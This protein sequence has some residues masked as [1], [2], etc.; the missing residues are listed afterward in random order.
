MSTVSQLIDNAEGLARDGDL[1]EAEELYRRVLTL[2]NDNTA[3]TYALGRLCSRDGRAAEAV[4]HYRR[5]LKQSGPSADCL[6]NLAAALAT[7]GKIAEAE[8][9]FAESIALDA[10]KPEAHFGHAICLESLDRKADAERA[11]RAAIAKK[12]AFVEA[13]NNLGALLLAQDR[14]SEA[15]PLLDQALSLN[16]DFLSARFNR[17][18]ACFALGRHVEAA[19]EFRIVLKSTPGQPDALNELGRCM[20]KQSKPHDA[21]AIF[22]EGARQHPTDPRF[23]VNLARS[24]ELSNDLAAAE[25]AL[26]RAYQLEPN[27]PSLIFA[28]ATLEYRQGKLP[29]ARLRLEGMLSMQ[30]LSEEQ[31]SEA[32]LELGLVLDE[33][34]EASAAFSTLVEGKRLRSRS[35][36][37]RAADGDQFLGLVEA[38]RTWFTKERISRLSQD[39][40]GKADFVT[41]FFV[42]FPRSGTTLIERALKAHPQISTTDERSPLEAVLRNLLSSGNYPK[43]LESVSSDDLAQLRQSFV[44]QAES[45]FGPLAG[46]VL[47][48]KMPMNIVHLGLINC[49]FPE[50]RV[51]IALRDPRDVC[52]SCF[53]QRFSLSGAM[54]NFLDLRKTAET[55][56]AVMGLWLHYREVIGLPWLEVRYE[57]LVEDFEGQLHSLT[58]FINLPWHS[59]I[60]SYRELAGQ[61]ATTTPSYRQVTRDIYETSVGR[62]RSYE[63]ELQDILPLLEPFIEALGYQECDGNERSITP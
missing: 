50:A 51:V 38:S 34:G 24:Y 37:V 15:L 43:C 62:W 60:L 13:L 28:L 5:Y 58:E 29:Q 48:D 26:A 45:A 40:P 9:A 47:F 3:A 54:V 55:Y 42:G 20:L 19:A 17:G 4:T 16:Y 63:K 41:V 53:M 18:I 7:L 46:K 25:N 61:P 44:E 31:K 22:R 35:Q 56:R 23:L 32:L 36:A 1:R 21:A 49:L 57:N 6:F 2:D 33:L 39:L 10:S 59:N 30:E 52:L 14:A 11:Y 27:S 12:P 8:T